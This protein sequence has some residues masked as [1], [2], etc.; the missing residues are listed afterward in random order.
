M[1]DCCVVLAA[2][3]QE[4]Q[5]EGK[6]V[7]LSLERDSFELAELPIV[8][9]NYRA[10]FNDIS[11]SSK[12]DYIAYGQGLNFE[13]KEV[14]SGKTVAALYDVLYSAWIRDTDSLVMF[15]QDASYS[16]TEHKLVVLD[17]S[18]GQTQ[19]I[20]VLDHPVWFESVP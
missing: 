3:Q 10:A 13:I 15:V 4:G 1:S 6:P 12:A 5:K 14:S 11:V 19:T 8:P 17:A 16:S 9:T 18:T 7:L 2:Y 20:L